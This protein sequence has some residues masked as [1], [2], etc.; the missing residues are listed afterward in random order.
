MKQVKHT[1]VEGD[2]ILEIQDLPTGLYF[3][4]VKQYGV[5]IGTNKVIVT[6]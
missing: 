3:V 5:T 1:S 6:K 2:N 4:V